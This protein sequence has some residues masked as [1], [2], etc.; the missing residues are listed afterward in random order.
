MKRL[1]KGACL[2]LLNLNFT[3]VAA[4]ADSGKTDGQPAPESVTTT[5]NAAKP[6]VVMLESTITG[7]QEQPKVL[8]IVPWQ[9]PADPPSLQQWIDGE[10]AVSVLA[11]LERPVLQRQLALFQ[12]T[13]QNKAQADPTADQ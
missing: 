2:L 12:M 13:Q 4:A 10:A 11:P 3:F 6:G 5:A 1:C 9:A 7:S 8:Y